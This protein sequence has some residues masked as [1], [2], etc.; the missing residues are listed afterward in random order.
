MKSFLSKII[1]IIFDIFIILISIYF[2]FLFRGESVNLFDN[3]HSIPLSQYFNFYPMYIITILLFVYEGIYTYRYDFWHESRLI[4]K[5]II[6]SALLVFSYLAMT[7]SIADYSRVVIGVAFIFIA[8]LI[9]LAKNITKKLLYKLGLWRKKAAI[10]GNDPFLI[11]E[12]Y[13]N[14][15]LGYVRPKADEEPSTV[16]VNSKD[17][18]VTKLH[19]II[20]NEITNRH[21]VIFIP[22]MDEYDLTHSHIYELSNTRTNLIVFQNRLKSNYRL[23]FKKASDILLSLFTFPLLL[24]ILIIIAYKIK[25]ENPHK[26]IFFKQERIGKNE[27]EFICYKFRTME[28]GGDELLREYLRAHPEEIENYAKYHKYINDPRITKIGQFLRRTSLDELPQIFN[29]LKGE[30]SFI[31]PRPYMLNEKKKIGEDLSNVLT[32]KPGITGLWQV[33]GR[34][35]VDFSE[36]VNLDVWYIQNWNLWMDLVILMKTVRTV[37]LRNGAS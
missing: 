7:N 15:Y 13:N 34:N 9:P 6:F 32:V 5:G 36:R 14:P 10:Y 2:A 3:V 35:N 37:I 18:N 24:P 12:I 4:F 33:S 1:F 29:V 19:Q 23:L 16:F 20:K 22:L 28:E 30:M 31:G 27:K 26:P 25:K 17:T 11:A 8:I 21:E